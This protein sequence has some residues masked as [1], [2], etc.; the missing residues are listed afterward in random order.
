MTF[1]RSLLPLWPLD[2]DA[3]YLNHG[4]VGV[5]PH[6]VL[7]AQRRWRDR[8]ERHPARFMLRE[9]WS[10]TGSATDGPSLMR[11]AAA[12]VAH[13]VGARAD[14]LVFVDNT[15][16]GINA[17]M[18]S[19]PLA[20]GDEVIIT[21][22]AYGGIVTAVR[23]CAA[24]AGATV[25]VVEMPYP[26][27]RADECVDRIAAALTARTRLV[28]VDHIAAESAIVFPV[29]R[30]VRA[31]HDRQV[32]VLVDGAHVPGQM[33]LDV[34]SIGAD[35][36]IANLHKWAMAPRSSAFMVVAPEQ[37]AMMHPPVISW[38]FDTGF[39]RE[40]DWVGT[41]DPTPWLCAPDGFRFLHGLGDDARITYCHDL[42]WRAAQTLT[43]HWH[44]PLEIDESAVASMVSVMTP[45]H[46]GT[47]RPDAVALRDRLLHD[48]N[49]EVQTH[50]R[51]GRVWIR[52]CA[53]VYNDDEDIQRLVA[54]VPCQR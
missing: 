33:P 27:F 5:T 26:A 16:T 6:A 24:R 34:A 44:T 10:F 38:G 9:L 47:T 2:P 23:Y 22:H 12:E 35:I 13:V 50:A 43:S 25:R 31:C 8:I 21:D 11:Q 51:A 4:T 52:L 20:P 14:D 29:E 15:S 19:L 3:T 41:R 37:Q 1:G 45:E 39:A 17:V 40:F 53:Q 28:L 49:L 48:H 30:I 7:D 54:A 18:R 32:P 42:A 36:Y 46:C